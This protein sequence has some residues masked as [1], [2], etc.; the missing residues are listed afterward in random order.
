VTSDERD[1]LAWA[2]RATTSATRAFGTLTGEVVVA[3]DG[4]ARR[5]IA[6]REG[7]VVRDTV[8]IAGSMARPPFYPSDLPFLPGETVTITP[9]AATWARIA[10]SMRT[11]VEQLVSQA[12]TILGD[13][14]FSDVASRARRIAETARE[15]RQDAVAQFRDMI[16]DISHETREELRRSVPVIAKVPAANDVFEAVVAHHRDDHW[17]LDEQSGEDDAPP[18]VL[19]RK[20]SQ[21]RRLSVVDSMGA[22]L[23]FLERLGTGEP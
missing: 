22:S 19:A 15:S 2:Q 12:E 14:R 7:E 9:S 23:V 13:P 17:A 18:R 1:L 21:R 3:P 10:P 16:P 20:G 8:Q 4:K 5:I 6:L 11:L